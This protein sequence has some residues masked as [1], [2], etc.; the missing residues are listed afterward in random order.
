M[1]ILVIQQKMIGDVLTSSILFEALRH[2]YPQAQLDYLINEH[3]FPVVDQNPFIDNFVFFTKKE[4]QSKQELLKF[5]LSIRK[6][7][8][9]VII[10]V[11]SKFSSNLIS[12]LSSAAIKI[13]KYKWYTSFIYTNTFNDAKIKN[14]NAGLAVENRLQLL[15]PI[16]NYKP[17]VFK[18]K[19]YLTAEEL[20]NSKRFLQQNNIDL[21]K[22]LFMISV[23]GSSLKKTYP[24]FYMA[25]LIDEIV[26][27][28][29][30]QILFN[31]I[32]NQEQDAKAIYNAC[33]PETQQQIKFDVFGKSLREF[34]AITKHCTALIG[35]EGG[36]VNMAKAIDVPTFTVF[37]PWITKAAWNM[38]EDGKIHVSI[39]LNDVKPEIYNNRSKKYLKAN[40]KRLYETFTP[41]LILEKLNLFLKEN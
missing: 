8:Y 15:E 29:K 20:K 16:L 11:Y 12:F 22:P 13:S 1:K 5:A 35:N 17:Q 38:F 26:T 10:D 41:D 24:F 3:T 25:R 27:T 7:N 34:I 39:H 19:I 23:L 2:K 36:A 18:P 9:D 40:Y 4:E 32:P 14:T 28:T 31:Y 37:S 21:S 30:G 6:Q 33:K